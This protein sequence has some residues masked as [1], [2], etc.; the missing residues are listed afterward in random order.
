MEFNKYQS[1]LEQLQ[2]DS[3]PDEVREDFY[4]CLN[5]PF[6]KWMISPDRPRAKDLERDDK[7]RII[8][9]IVHPHIL[10]DM[11]YFRPTAIH[12]QKTGRFTDLKPN[13]NPN[14]AFGKWILEEARRCREGYV[15]ES[16]GE[17][18]TGNMYFFMNYFPIA[19]TKTIAG[20]KK[21]KRIVDF[22][23]MWDGIYL[24]FHYIEQAQHGGKYDW[25]GG[26][27][28]SEVSSRGKSKSYTMASILTKYFF[29]GESEEIKNAVKVLA[30]AYSSEYLIKDGILNKFQSCLDFL[31]D[32]TQFPHIMLKNSLQEMSWVMGW[33]DINNI[34][35][36][37]LNEVTGVAV[38]DDVGKIRGKRQNF[39]V[40]EEFGNFKNVRELYNLLIP[41]LTEGDY[42]F[43]TLYAIGTSGDNESNFQQT[44]ELIY[45]P[46]GYRMYALPNVWD[47]PGEGRKMI[48]F[49]FP[50]Y[51][52]RKG[53]YDENGNSNVTG[54]LVEILYDRYR[55]KYN[56]TDI[57]SI[58]RNIAE[59][60]ITPTEALMRSKGNKFPVNDLNQRLAQLD[61]NSK[62]W[63]DVYVGELYIDGNGE[64]QFKPT[65]DSPI[66]QYPI[67]NN[68]TA[69]ALEIFAM[70]EKDS[71]GKVFS[72]RYI[73]G[74]DPIDFDQTTSSTSLYSTFIFDLF[75]D[76]IVAEYTGRKEYADENYEVSRLLC[77]FY[78]ATLLYENNLKGTFAYFSRMSSLSLLA[79]TPE[80]LV[81]KLNYKIGG[82]GNQAKGIRAIQSVNSY[83][84]DLIREWL[85]Q[86]ETV[87]VKDENGEDVEITRRHLYSLRNRALL[88]EMIQYNPYG[89]FDRI[90]SLGMVMLYREAFRILYNGDVRHDDTDY[91]DKSMDPFFLKNFGFVQT[92]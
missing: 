30:I 90:R 17:W 23:E 43:G 48:T 38:K 89:N 53:Y 47:K 57:N 7:G 75:T 51:V 49:F 9:D 1:T 58:V 14:S 68:M 87:V 65:N 26:R 61:A 72:N 19:Q 70:P 81:S 84:D 18:V 86:P 42:S 33:K 28:G 46:E 55:I 78:N 35:H 92:N 27:N 60:P 62:E 54:A 4:E 41:S 11:D 80:Y 29:L 64:V 25:R 16:D 8:V 77:L 3:L 56:T 31:A 5:I 34:R 22:P 79:D 50:E 2:L 40:L 63:D 21:G 39:I 67:D 88:Q 20:S 13:S 24:R 69:G 82:I 6:I 85:I 91:V 32:N 12:F 52:D 74:L 37:T 66:R 10:E 59:R 83:A 71:R 15:R 45:N 44:I 76:T 73:G 36:G